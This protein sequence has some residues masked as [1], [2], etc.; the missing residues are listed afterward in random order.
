MRHSV[1]TDEICAG[2]RE[3]GGKAFEPLFERAS[4]RNPIYRDFKKH[5]VRFQDYYV[6]NA[7]SGLT[8][9]PKRIRTLIRVLYGNA[10]ASEFKRLVLPRN[11][12]TLKFDIIEEFIANHNFKRKNDWERTLIAEYDCL[13]K[14]DVFPD[15]IMI[16]YQDAINE[17]HELT[18]TSIKEIKKIVEED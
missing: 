10:E 15:S 12:N 17:F 3:T 6:E 18:L 7:I 9:I 16:A 5:L 8:I 11:M 14:S 1:E 4:D 2:Q 13:K